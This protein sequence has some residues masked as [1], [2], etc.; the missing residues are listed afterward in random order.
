MPSVPDGSFHQSETNALRFLSD[1][2]L[3]R[4]LNPDDLV[5]ALL[6]AVQVFLLFA[7]WLFARH[8]FGL[9]AAVWASLLLP[10]SAVQFQVYWFVYLKQA[11]SMAMILIM[12]ERWDR[13]SWWA[14]P[15]GGFVA[16]LHTMSFF[17]LGL[18]L[19]GAAAWSTLSVLRGYERRPATMLQ[20]LWR[21]PRRDTT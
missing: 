17:L 14:V 1:L 20:A 15:L 9:E 2:L 5:F 16:G 12:L 8:S 19:L 4:G 21:V 3:L 7:V 18:T 11:F 10:L 6:L 13:R